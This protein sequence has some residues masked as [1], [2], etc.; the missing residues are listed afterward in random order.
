[1]TLWFILSFELPQ[2]NSIF[3][4]LKMTDSVGL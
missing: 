3:K 4:L 1:M 2:I